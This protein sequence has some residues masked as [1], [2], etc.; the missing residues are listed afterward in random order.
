MPS[1]EV[2][3]RDEEGHDLPLG[4]IGEICLRGPQVMREYW[5]RPEETAKVLGKDGF[6]KSGDLGF[7]DERGYVKLVERK[8]DVIIVSGFNV[9]PNE[10]E[11]V[12]ALLPGVLEVAA[13]GVPDDHSGEVVKVFIV[14]QDKSLSEADIMAYCRKNLASYK[15]PKRIE[16]CES[17]PKTTVGKILRRVLREQVA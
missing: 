14:R 7:M 10:V 6:L 15:C 2:V 9:Y 11:D 1:T 3:I 17:L 8:K 12:L 5:G 4:E 16:F 13:I